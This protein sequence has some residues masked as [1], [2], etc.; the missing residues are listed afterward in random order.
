MTPMQHT[1]IHA[2]CQSARRLSCRVSPK[3]TAPYGVRMPSPWGLKNTSRPVGAGTDA[4]LTDMGYRGE[5]VPGTHGDWGRQTPWQP[6][7]G[8]APGSTGAWGGEPGGYAGEE[9]Y[10][11]HEGNGANYG[12]AGGYTGPPSGPHEGQYGDPYAQSQYEQQQ[13][14]DQQPYPQQSY[15]LQRYDKP[16][17]PHEQTQPYQQQQPYEQQQQPYEQYG[18]YGPG[19]G[20]AAG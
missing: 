15:E 14:Y 11:Q 20:G 2:R 13:P 4:T 12:Q 6:S 3:P 17:Q 8:A 10:P 18:G 5:D 7:S 1:L 16:K 19:Q 9:S